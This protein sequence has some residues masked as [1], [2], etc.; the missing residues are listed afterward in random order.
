M[1]AQKPQQRQQGQAED[2]EEIALDPIEQ[3]RAGP[4]KLIATDGIKRGGHS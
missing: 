1:I 4:F 2:C 3:L